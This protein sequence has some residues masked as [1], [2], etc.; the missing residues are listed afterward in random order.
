MVSIMPVNSATATLSVRPCPGDPSIPQHFQVRC[1]VS[2]SCGS[3]LSNEATYSICPADFNCSGFV[4][5]P[6]IF[7]FLSAWFANDARADFDGSGL[8]VTVPDIFAFLSV[9]FAGCP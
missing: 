8:P 7:A 4:E 1:I 6:D 5:V 3:I 9:W 2:N